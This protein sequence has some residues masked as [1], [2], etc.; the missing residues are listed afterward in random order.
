MGSSSHLAAPVLTCSPTQ[1]WLMHRSAWKQVNGV[2][3]CV[4]HNQAVESPLT[5]LDWASL[6]L[7]LHHQGQR[8]WDCETP[9]PGAAA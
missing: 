4:H 6:G 8:K 7:R 1:A 2:Q 5:G 9:T 3:C